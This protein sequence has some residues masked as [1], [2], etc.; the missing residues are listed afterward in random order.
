MYNVFTNPFIPD[1]TGFDAVLDAIG[2]VNFGNGT[3][4]FTNPAHQAAF[5]EHI[6]VTDQEM[7]DSLGSSFTVVS[8]SPQFDPGV[9]VEG[10][11]PTGGF[12]GHMGAGPGM[13]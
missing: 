10:D 12:N 8:Q 5:D 3:Y 4:R 11:S 2:S 6:A 1:G 9:I 7:I 13:S